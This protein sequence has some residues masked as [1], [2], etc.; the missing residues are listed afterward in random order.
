VSVENISTSLMCPFTT[1]GMSERRKACT[2]VWGTKW[3]RIMAS[4]G[5]QLLPCKDCW[6]RRRL[7]LWLPPS[8]LSSVVRRD[9]MSLSHCLF[10][11]T[12]RQLFAVAVAVLP[13]PRE[14]F[15]FVFERRAQFYFSRYDAPTVFRSGLTSVFR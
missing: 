9:I 11:W 1:V 15:I 4:Q 3:C 12:V 2:V 5:R 13:L 6:K 7:S 14:F 10:I 8:W